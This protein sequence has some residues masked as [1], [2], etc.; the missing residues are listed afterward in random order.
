MPEPQA[1][2][3]VQGAQ[4][5]L[6]SGQVVAGHVVRRVLGHGSRSTVYLA[7]PK[8]STQVVALKVMPL[9]SLA[10]HPGQEAD[11]ALQAFLN[12]AER[13]RQ[14]RQRD[15]VKVLGFGVEAPL[16]WL[17]MEAVPGSDL[18]RY[19]R[20][21]RLLPLALVLQLGQ[22]LARA[23]AHA[24]RAGVIHRDVKPSNILVHWPTHTI[25]LADFGLAQINGGGHTGTGLMLGSPAY[26]APEQLTGAQLVPATDLY[27]LGVTLYE[28]LAGQPAFLA[29]TM[30]EL[31]RQVTQEAAP[32]LAHLQ[33]E[34]PAAL[35]KLLQLLMA[36]DPDQR[37]ANG[38]LVAQQLEPLLAQ[39]G[40][41]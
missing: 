6:A 11:P 41:V 10:S 5:A 2:P 40:R 3:G 18:T 25:K 34:L 15:L 27:A 39:L 20:R 29:Q 31:L 30:G 4:P 1:Q 16:A 33:P 28:L 35:P 23:L 17:T 38:D 21:P 26:M 32:N 19:T 37:P 14:L 13:S 36:K 9:S 22:R 8:G 24:H 12:A 7:A